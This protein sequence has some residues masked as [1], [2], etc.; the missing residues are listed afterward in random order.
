MFNSVLVTFPESM[1]TDLPGGSVYGDLVER[2]GQ[3]GPSVGSLPVLRQRATKEGGEG[4]DGKDSREDDEDYAGVEF[5]REGKAG[6]FN[7]GKLSASNDEYET[8]GAEKGAGR[9][10]TTGGCGFRWM[11]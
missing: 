5:G 10:F 8:G 3:G 11:K 1:E 7:E 9:K 2:I 4:F 6:L